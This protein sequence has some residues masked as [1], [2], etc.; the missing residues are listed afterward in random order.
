MNFELES[1]KI[2]TRESLEI[3]KLKHQSVLEKIALININIDSLIK[4][5]NLIWSNTKQDKPLIQTVN[6]L[7]EYLDLLD[8][9]VR[10]KDKLELEI[11]KLEGYLESLKQADPDTYE[12]REI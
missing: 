2:D 6:E 7:Y 1:N 12:E 11:S 4:E 9:T 8:S 3:K 5:V 10:C